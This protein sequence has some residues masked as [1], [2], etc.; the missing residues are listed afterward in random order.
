MSS[1]LST[2]PGRV[3]LPGPQFVGDG[4]MRQCDLCLDLPTSLLTHPRWDDLA[5]SQHSVLLGLYLSANSIS[6]EV[7]FRKEMEESDNYG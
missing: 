5:D 4:P 7:N 6:I 1:G 3:S 2:L